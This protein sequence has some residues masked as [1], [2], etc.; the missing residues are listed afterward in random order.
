[1]RH[2]PAFS[3]VL[4]RLIGVLCREDASLSRVAG[5]IEKDPVLA[6]NVLRMV[7]SAL[8][9]RL[10][11][12]HTV[13]HAVSVLGMERLRNAVI[14]LSS[15]RMWN[16]VPA[17]DGWSVRE[18]NRHSFSVAILADLIAQRARLAFSESA[19]TA[20]LFHDAGRL[21]IAS[22]LRSEHAEIEGR[23]QE[24]GRKRTDCEREVLGWTHAELSGDVLAEWRLPEVIAAG[25]RYHED[26]EA[27]PGA[28]EGGAPCLSRV[29]NAADDFVHQERGR[30]ELPKLLRELGLVEDMPRILAAFQSEMSAVRDLL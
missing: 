2:L 14:G 24:P 3:P 30:E 6:G 4:N 29:I 9:G 7:N 21:L 28:Q 19:F 26:P 12:V 1:M 18:F 8:Y 25:V 13:R 27:D 23:M 10:G 17:A 15:F 5:T 20:G 11:R 16:N 22:S